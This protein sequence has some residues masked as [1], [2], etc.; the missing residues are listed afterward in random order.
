MLDAWGLG[1]HA[2]L[3]LTEHGIRPPRQT[4]FSHQAL[5]EHKRALALAMVRLFTP[6]EIRA[7]SLANLNRWKS[8]GTTVSAYD[9]WRGLIA[10][11]I[12]DRTEWLVNLPP[13]ADWSVSDYLS[14][15]H[16]ERLHPHSGAADRPLAGLQQRPLRHH[17]RSRVRE[18]ALNP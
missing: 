6:Q 7:K 8:Q 18:H 1:E 2:K 9:E 4:G 12:G 14:D 11:N 16:T 17:F 10:K 13:G 15:R 5:D 3:V